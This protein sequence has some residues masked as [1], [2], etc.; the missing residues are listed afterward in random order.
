MIY[1][2]GFLFL[3][4][5]IF[6]YG[7][8]DQVRLFDS[9]EAKMAQGIIGRH[10]KMMT[11]CALPGSAAW[12]PRADVGG[13]PGSSGPLDPPAAVRFAS[14]YSPQEARAGAAPIDSI[15]SVIQRDP[16]V[17]GSYRL[18]TFGFVA[19][20][21]VGE[22]RSDTLRV[23]RTAAHLSS[24]VANYG[25]AAVGQRAGVYDRAAG[26]VHFADRRQPRS[27][28]FNPIGILI[29]D[30]APAM[31]SPVLNASVP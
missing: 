24:I 1:M 27:V 17:P 19:G 23:G 15:A 12:C 9:G 7:N 22:D 8:Q 29:P 6:A 31:V 13:S 11:T 20:S 3:L 18:F 5:G 14:R 2:I 21:P 25:E 10:G 28:P 16:A 26:V 30:G 4:A